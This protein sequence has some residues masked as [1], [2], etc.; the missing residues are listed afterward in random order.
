MSTFLEIIKVVLGSVFVL[1]LPGY[2]LSLIFLKKNTIDVI[3]RTAVS[4]A[5]SISVVPL[6]TFYLNLAGVRITRL[7]VFIEVTAII[8][9]S[10]LYLF[11]SNHNKKNHEDKI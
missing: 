8:F 3:E 10:I 9:I 5:L 2:F 1:Y 11:L 6:I 4:F 7:S